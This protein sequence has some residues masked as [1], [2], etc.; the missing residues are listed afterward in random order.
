MMICS[1]LFVVLFCVLTTTH[2]QSTEVYAVIVEPGNGLGTKVSTVQVQEDGSLLAVVDNI[3]STGNYQ[4][5]SGFSAFDQKNEVFYFATDSD[6]YIYISDIP[7]KSLHPPIVTNLTGVYN[8]NW[9]GVKNVVY[10]DGYNLNERNFIVSFIY[11]YGTA[12]SSIEL[13]GSLPDNI[14]ILHSTV[15][16]KNSLYYFV[17][18]MNRLYTLQL[19]NPTNLT[20]GQVICNF[21]QY[22]YVSFLYY[23]NVHQELVLVN[24]TIRTSITDLLSLTNKGLVNLP[25]SICLEVVRFSVWR[26]TLFIKNCTLH[27]KIPWHFTLL[28]QTLMYFH[29]E[30]W[31]LIW[32]ISLLLIKHDL[33]EEESWAIYKLN[34]E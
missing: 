18:P 21:T 31:E 27:M 20:R 8:I 25:P 14:T 11:Q 19:N 13:I 4:M 6:S 33:L 9:D 17:D 30:M 34:E 10:I 16:W 1:V 22:Y 29:K 28:I 23:D 26:M 24:I 15:D 3:L 32:M 5:N 7:N 12:D 2:A